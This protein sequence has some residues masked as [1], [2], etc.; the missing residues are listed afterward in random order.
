VEEVSNPG[1]GGFRKSEV[2]GSGSEVVRMRNWRGQKTVEYMV[3]VGGRGFKQSLV[4]HGGE[5]C[6]AR[7]G[8][9]T[10]EAPPFSFTKDSLQ[11]VHLGY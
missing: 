4:S 11:T 10:R 8:C 5:L 7:V 9:S 1:G 2:M 6:N 3:R